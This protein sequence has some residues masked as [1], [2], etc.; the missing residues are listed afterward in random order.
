MIKAEDVLED[1]LR[2][3][4]FKKSGWKDKMKWLLI[5]PILLLIIAY[6]LITW[7]PALFLS[8]IEKIVNTTWKLWNYIKK[9]S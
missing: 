1:I 3:R 6:H 8:L 4:G 7:I 5:Y 2:F 9:K